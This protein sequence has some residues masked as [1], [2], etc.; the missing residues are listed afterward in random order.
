MPDEAIPRRVVNTKG[1]RVVFLLVDE[2]GSRAEPDL[3]EELAGEHE[4][5]SMMR[6]HTS[7]TKPTHSPTWRPSQFECEMVVSILRFQHGCIGFDQ[8]AHPTGSLILSSSDHR[9]QHRWPDPPSPWQ[10]G[11]YQPDDV[12]SQFPQYLLF[13]KADMDTKRPLI[14]FTETGVR[15]I[16]M[17]HITEAL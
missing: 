16:M 6:P 13:T 3:C 2:D 12:S 14:V 1:A 15:M 10:G 7:T 11:T 4:D 5:A 9:Q 17:E 8:L